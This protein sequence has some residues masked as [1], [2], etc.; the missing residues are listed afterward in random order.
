MT[1][2]TLN[3]RGPNQIPEGEPSEYRPSRATIDLNKSITDQNTN[4]LDS[5]PMYMKLILEGKADHT[6]YGSLGAIRGIQGRYDELIELTQKALQLKPNHHIYL[7][8]LGNAQKAKGN[9]AD[10]ISYYKKAIALMPE[11]AE[12]HNNLGTVLHDQGLF[13]EAIIS[14]NQALSFRENYAEA[15][16]NLGF[17][18]KE[19]GRLDKAI[20]FHTKAIDLKPDFAEG[21][22]NLGNTLLEMGEIDEALEAYVNTLK[23]NPNHAKALVNAGHIFNDRGE[24]IAA[25]SSYKKAIQLDPYLVQAQ[26]SL[27]NALEERTNYKEALK[28]FIN[29]LQINHDDAETHLGISRNLLHTGNIKQ[30]VEHAKLAI[31]IDPKNSNC[32]CTL[33]KCER[34]QGDFK[35]SKS[36][37]HKALQADPF[38]TAA[39]YLLSTQIADKTEA[40]KLL[41]LIK[42][43]EMRGH[44]SNKSKASSEFAKANCFHKLKKYEQASLHLTKANQLKLSYHPSDL[45]KWQEK[46]QASLT[47]PDYFQND[48]LE[49]GSNRIFIVGVPRCGSTLLESI[50]A[51]NPILQDLGETNALGQAIEQ[52]LKYT[53]DAKH[54][55]LESLY[56]KNLGNPCSPHTITIDKNLYNFINARH[57]VRLMPSAKII[58]CHRHPLDNILSMLRADLVFGNNYTSDPADAAKFLILQEETLR[59]CKED[60][61]GRI[62]SLNYDAFVNDPEQI[63]RPLIAWLG[64]EWS[65]NYLH[66]ELAERTIL[67]ASV[68]QARQPINNKSVGGWKNYK[69][70]LEP[71]VQILRN[72]NLYKNFIFEDTCP[73]RKSKTFSFF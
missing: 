61:P 33:S 32:F 71:A 72:S 24:D 30:A 38:D 27:A 39:F 45:S 62:F 17:S 65:E 14:Y 34:S 54:Q 8:N 20:E 56:E 66:P 58:H 31:S 10:A 7:N 4:L 70:L 11:F 18:L 19:I 59:Q 6:I 42:T 36:S 47:C 41:S 48:C 26:N 64:L 40:E 68:V 51:T 43:A 57:I 21:Y 22:F 35:A 53:K 44:K 29:S 50:L 37:L 2:N 9:I 25:F 55:S 63:L 60:H 73:M 1:Q 13:D 16:N 12:A 69:E 67:T 49:D 23:L 52:A 46:N 28:Y 15:Y 3:D 5:E